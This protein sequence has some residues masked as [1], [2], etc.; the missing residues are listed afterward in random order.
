MRTTTQTTSTVLATFVF[1]SVVSNAAVFTVIN[2]ADSGSGSLRWAIQQAEAIPGNDTIN[3]NIPAAGGVA[4]ILLATPLPALWDPA[5]VTI[6]GFSQP[7]ASPGPNPPATAT[8]RVRLDGSA[9]VPPVVPIAPTAYAHGIWIRSSHNDI[10]GLVLHSFPHDGICIQASLPFQGAFNNRVYCCFSGTDPTGTMDWGNGRH[11]GFS[12]DLWAGIYI[13]LVPGDPGQA[14]NNVIEHCLSSGN[15]AEGI[16]ISSCPSDGDVSFNIVRNN[17]VGTRISGQGPIPI[18][19]D[20]DGVY[21]GEGTHDNVV[22]NNIVC[23]NGFEGV[24]IVG[25]AEARIFTDRNIVRNNR[26]GADV[27]LNP[28]PNTRHG[29]SIGAYGTHYYG[30]YAQYNQILNNVIAFNGR[31]GVMVWE[32]W[33]DNWANADFNTISQNAIYYNGYSDPGYLGIDLQE[34]GLTLNDTGD[35]D[36]G[37][38]QFVNFPVINSLTFNPGAVTTSIGGFVQINSDPTQA[39]VEVFKALPDATGKQHGQAQAYVG[40][41]TPDASGNWGFTVFGVLY[42]GDYVTATTT[43][44]YGNTSEFAANVLVPGEP[45]W[46][47]GDAPEPPFPTKLATQPLQPDGARHWIPSSLRLGK[48]IDSEPDGQPDPNAVGDDAAGLMDEDGILFTESFIPGQQATVL[49]TASA[50]G[51]LNAWADFDTNGVWS[52]AEQISVSQPLTAGA[53]RI[54]FVVPPSA[55]PL[56]S[57]F[58]RFRFSTLPVLAPTGPAPDGEVE[59]VFLHPDKAM[60]IDCGDAPDGPYPT[61]FAN[62]GARHVLSPPLFCLG[63]QVDGEFDGQPNAS[64]SGDDTAMSPDDEDGVS[65]PSQIIVG[66]SVAVSVTMTSADAQA[67]ILDAW[68]DFDN[69]GSWAQSADHC[70]QKQNIMPGVNSYGINIPATAAL[71]QTYARFRLSRLVGISYTGTF[72]GGE[73]EDYAIRIL[74]KPPVVSVTFSGTNIVLKWNSVQGALY[75]EVYATSD[76]AKPFPSGWTNLTPAGITTTTWQDT[77]ASGYRFYRVTAVLP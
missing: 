41:A 57:V 54:V 59:D 50:N 77:I 70:I 72:N 75:Y 18:P 53:N 12:G 40:T 48:L 16:G 13:V 1:A 73:V 21:L 61:L 42:P 22:E 7:G 8:L 66:Q 58:V 39:R 31:N 44:M 46:D 60:P 37:P 26:I 19:N 10:R 2:S 20:H 5:G 45:N 67:A 35:V 63:K 52:A 62:D 49:V 47:F 24:C 29:V 34:D 4:T 38:N 3:F 28:M 51:F 36:I 55:I 27:N 14:H 76:I 15:W 43:D 6:D 71:G 9:I 23:A 69:D 65:F 74:P 17:F 30:G 68:I 32:H 56:S 33:Q 25:Y 64:A 11:R